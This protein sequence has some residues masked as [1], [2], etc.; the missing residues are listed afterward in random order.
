MKYLGKHFAHFCMHWRLLLLLSQLHLPKCLTHCPEK[1]IVKN[2]GSG[3]I[4]AYHILGWWTGTNSQSSGVFY[5]TIALFVLDTCL[6]AQL[7]E[8]RQGLSQQRQTLSFQDRKHLDGT[9]PSPSQQVNGRRKPESKLVETSS[10]GTHIC[11]L[12]TWLGSAWRTT[13]LSWTTLAWLP[14]WKYEKGKMQRAKRFSNWTTWKWQAAK[15]LQHDVRNFH[16]SARLE[17]SRVLLAFPP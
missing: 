15:L 2:L 3:S 6:R 13:V 8:Q 11:V 9:V 5:L 14:H 12:C 4:I 10:D 16:A 7:C 1:H 17:A